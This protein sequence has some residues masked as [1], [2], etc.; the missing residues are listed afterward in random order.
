MQMNSW[1]TESTRGGKLHVKRFTLT[2]SIAGNADRIVIMVLGADG[3]TY[4]IELEPTELRTMRR[5]TAA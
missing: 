2:K 3:R 1:K 4:R 5:L